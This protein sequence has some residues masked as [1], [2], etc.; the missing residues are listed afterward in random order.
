[1]SER[2]TAKQIKQDIRED[3]VQSFLITAIMRFQDNPSLYLILVGG[4]LA[5]GV[6]ITVAFGYMDK[7]AVEGQERLATVMDLYDAPI[8]EADAKPE[9]ADDPSFASKEDRNAKVEAAL[10]DVHGSAS[11]VADLYEA[12]LA[13]D[14]GDK[15]KAREIWESFLRSHKDHA[16]GVTVQL[17]LLALDR[18][19]GKAQEVADQLQQQLDGT[20]K[21]LPEDVLLF[22]L[23]KTRKELGETQDAQDLFQRILDDYP[24]SAYAGEARKETTAG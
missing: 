8:V 14:A 12:R 15:A 20:A 6:G 5:L 7:R 21:S 19:E 3:E 22:E 24:T 17:N 1:M 13:L 11:E 10:D 23:A 16:L 18:A 4:I 2:L 9:D